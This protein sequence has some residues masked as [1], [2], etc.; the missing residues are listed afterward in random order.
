MQSRTTSI[1]A[2]TALAL[3]AFA[4]PLEASAQP[5]A[6]QGDPGAPDFHAGSFVNAGEP[7]VLIEGQPAARLGDVTFCP[8]TCVLLVPPF[9]VSHGAGVILVG[10]S[11]VRIGGQAAARLGDA[12][13]ETALQPF[14]QCDPNHAI[15][16]GSATVFIGP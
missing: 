14:P 3:A 8:Q 16:G 15:S 9:S 7:T 2:L 10:S 6:R 11:T 4:T 13:L 12:I 1:V 5:A